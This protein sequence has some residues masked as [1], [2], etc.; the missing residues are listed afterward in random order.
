MLWGQYCIIRLA[1]IYRGRAVPV[2]WRVLAHESSSV[3][4]ETYKAKL[5]R[6]AS[7]LPQR[8]RVILLADRGFADT[9]R[10]AAR[11]AA[12]GLALPHSRQE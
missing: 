7:L 3:A 2:V 5:N 4:F 6:A 9:K 10:S 8:V 11:P 12:I 1:V